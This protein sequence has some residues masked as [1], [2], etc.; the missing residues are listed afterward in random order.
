MSILKII[1]IQS[2]K[3]LLILV[4]MVKEDKISNTKDKNIKKYENEIIK[5][6][7]KLKSWNLLSLDLEICLSLKILLKLKTLLL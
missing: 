4:N 1:L 7:A 2:M 6:L 5:I 3:Y